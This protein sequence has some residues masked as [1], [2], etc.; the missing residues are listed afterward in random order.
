[1]SKFK[2]LKYGQKE[3]IKELHTQ[4]MSA[5]DIAYRIGCS[6]PT[7]YKYLKTKTTQPVPVNTPTT[8]LNHK[9]EQVIEQIK[10]GNY[11]GNTAIKVPDGEY[12]SSDLFLVSALLIWGAELLYLTR[13]EEEGR[14]VNFY[15]RKNEDL[16]TLIEKY[17]DNILHAPL[18]VF[19]GCYKTLRYTLHNN[20]NCNVSMITNAC[21]KFIA[22]YSR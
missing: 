13:S 17:R 16:L 5:S 4:G 8:V 15:F 12:V 7:V 19:V 2:H 14:F 10:A 22:I 9:E 20:L 6:T 1:M 21:R 11:Y 18:N 3:A